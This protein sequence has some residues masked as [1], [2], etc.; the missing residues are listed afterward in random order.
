VQ[1]W[2]T[3]FKDQEQNDY[4]ACTTMGAGDTGYYVIDVFRTKLEYPQLFKRVIAMADKYKPDLIV[5]EDKASGQSLIQSLKSETRLPI[6]AIKVEN[7]KVLRAHL[8]TPT[9]E[10]GKVFLPH[11]AE[12]LND[13]LSEMSAFPLAANDDI[14]DSFNQ[15]LASLTKYG[16]NI[17]Y[18]R[19]D[20]KTKY[21]NN[22][23]K[24][25]I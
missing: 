19:S 7:D 12:W 10:A 24:G 2:D 9:I 1:S 23:F 14:V 11:R 25:M 15:N 21:S 6:K 3:A 4:S 18:G 16:R 13:F 22:F 17:T 20:T 5:I 8:A